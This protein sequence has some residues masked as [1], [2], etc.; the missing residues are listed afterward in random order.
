[1]CGGSCVELVEQYSNKFYK[2]MT[3]TRSLQVHLSYFKLVLGGQ[4]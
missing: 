2:S 1:M 4:I 3:Q